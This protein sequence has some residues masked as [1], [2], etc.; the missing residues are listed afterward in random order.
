MD[1]VPVFSSEFD[2]NAEMIDFGWITR[3]LP[4]AGGK[5][6]AFCYSRDNNDWLVEIANGEITKREVPKA[7]VAEFY[8][9]QHGDYERDDLYRGKILNVNWNESF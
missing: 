6:I 2:L 7:I 8:S 4:F 9:L 5:L 3:Y 1:L